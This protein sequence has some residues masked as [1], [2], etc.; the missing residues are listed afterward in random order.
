MSLLDLFLVMAKIGAFTIGGGYAMLLMIQKEVTSRGWI[1]DEEF[2]DLIALSQ[3]APGL[4]AVNISIF[5]G[6]KLR[7]LPGAAVATIGSCLPPFLII[8]LIAVFF[9]NY[10]D[11]PVVQRVFAGMRPAV[12]AL[13]AV[14]MIRMVR[15][16]CRKWWQY[17]V[18]AA[19][20]VLVSFLKVSPVYILIVVIVISLA[21]ALHKK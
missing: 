1:S 21:I 6:Y 14:P 12:V 16:S 15:N 9:S 10:A 7:G 8:L 17:A 19:A 11:E 13:I 5:T 18:T 3:A 2:P 4:L 20:L